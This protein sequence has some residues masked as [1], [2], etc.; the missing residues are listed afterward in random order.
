MNKI[1]NLGGLEL[2]EQGVVRDI[3]LPVSSQRH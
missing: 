3:K 1:S 2:Q